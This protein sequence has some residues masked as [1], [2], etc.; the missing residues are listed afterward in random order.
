M[1]LH[2]FRTSLLRRSLLAAAFATLAACSTLGPDYSGPPVTAPLAVERDHFIRSP[3]GTR[4]NE[5]IAQWW[6]S[7]DD[8]V[9]T[10]LVENTLANSPSIAIAEARI[11]QA[12]A[13]LAAYRTAEL[14]TLGGSLS[15]PYVNLPSDIVDTNPGSD[16][17]DLQR[18]SLG[19]DASWELDLFGGTARRTQAATARAEASEAQLADAQ[20]SLS[21]EFVRL[22]CTYRAQQAR[23]ELLR[24]LIA[25]DGQL[26]E[27]AQ[28]RF[29]Q[30]SAPRHPIEQARMEQARNLA[31]LAATQAQ[32]TM[33]ADQMAVLTGDEPGALDELLAEPGAVPLPPVEVAIGDPGGMLRQ[34]PDI[35]VAER[36]MAAASAEI[37]AAIADGFPKVS[38][39]GIFGLGGEDPG[40][41]LTSSDAIGLALPRISWSVFDGGRNRLKVRQR[42]AALA[43]A[44]AAY[45]SVVLSAL[46]DAEGA[47]TRFGAARVELEQARVAQR[48]ADTLADLQFLRSQAG[49]VKR[50][51]A[52][53]SRQ[54]AIQL[55]VAS[56]QAEAALTTEFV[57]VHKALGLGWI[58]GERE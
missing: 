9:L 39:F 45:R 29:D 57:S 17:I 5:P 32:V 55:A 22:Y 50:E 30:G 54:E 16:R 37:G 46:V 58:G 15:A 12:R 41:L 11:L 21:A 52:L 6:I 25:I 3:E 40:R 2:D 44:E 4:S 14:P 48:S 34:R 47:L 49:R 24:E 20:V 38:F 51:S 42:E 18:Y 33:L 27:L 36:K 53:V 43:E 28:L 31:A 1:L 35:R 7:L 56:R 8:P 19:F 13:G 23:V 10:R 26:I